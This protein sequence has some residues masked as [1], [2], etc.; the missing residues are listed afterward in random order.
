MGRKKVRERDD[1]RGGGAKEPGKEKSGEGREKVGIMAPTPLT[2][3]HAPVLMSQ[4]ILINRFSTFK[5]I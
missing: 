3:S 4:T 1:G 2:Y 5:E